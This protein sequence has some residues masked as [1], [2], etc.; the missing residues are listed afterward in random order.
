MF[1][2]LNIH[3]PY[4]GSR[5]VPQKNWVQSVLWRIRFAQ[6]LVEGKVLPYV[7]ETSWR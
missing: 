2:N 6:K 3:K 1:E 4:L 7:Q 5:E